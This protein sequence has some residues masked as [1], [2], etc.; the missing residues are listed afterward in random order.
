[1]WPRG[2]T[3][4][5]RGRD[6]LNRNQ[7]FPV[8]FRA[9]RMPARIHEFRAVGGVR[10]GVYLGLKSDIAWG[11]KSA[12]TPADIRH[13]QATCRH[14]YSGANAIRL[15]HVERVLNFAQAAFGVREWNSSEQASSRLLSHGVTASDDE[16]SAEVRFDLYVGLKSEVV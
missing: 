10:F 2:S 7:I 9:K 1:V 8:G 16:V 4:E 5:A 11:P 14:S 15:E 6:H 3:G 12:R 13:H